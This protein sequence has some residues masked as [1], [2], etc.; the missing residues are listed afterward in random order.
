MKKTAIS[1][2]CL[3]ASHLLF[4]QTPNNVILLL[5][6]GQSNAVGR[7]APDPANEVS[8]IAGT[9]WYKQSTN[10]IES[11]IDGIGENVSHATDRSM[12]PMLG[13]RIKELTGHD[14][15]IVP[16]GVGNTFISYW[17][18]E[19]NSLYTRAKQMWQDALAYCA[20]HNITV[21]G[22][23][24]HWLQGEND[25]GPTET[26]GYY[27]MLNQLTNDLIS[28]VG[29]EKVFATRI[30]YDPN[31]TVAANSEKIMKA[32]KILNYNNPNFIMDSYAPPT[33]TYA[34]GK[35]SYDL[36]HHALSGLN[37][38][39]NDVAT[40]I[41][42]YRTAGG[43]IPLTE[44]VASLQGVTSGYINLTPVW[45]FD[46]SN[47]LNEANDNVIMKPVVRDWITNYATTYS[48]DGGIVIN[49]YTG[50][51]TSRPFSSATFT[52]EVRLRMTTPEA[53]SAVVGDGNGGINNKLVIYYNTNTS[54]LY[55]QF[56]TSTGASSWDLG[57][58][59]NMSS[60]HTLKF[61]Q[62][63]GTLKFY[64]DGVQKGTDVASNATFTISRLGMG[65]SSSTYDMS[66]VIDFFR[67]KNTVD[68]TTLPLKFKSFKATNI[69]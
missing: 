65:A 44:T 30:A 48:N 24:A 13:K 33:F 14:V 57:N 40:A 55:V 12:N 45:S 68:N 50:L 25:A 5:N 2:L 32:Q 56:G 43:K 38:E 63:N 51:A 23:Y 31:Y 21:S 66:G 52:M 10:T 28:D 26:D 47:N 7:A 39:A 27:V 19:D 36:S 11:L 61:T 16:A 8:P 49:Q 53:W 6:I 58:T 37:Q 1:L 67:I 60:Y 17:L 29:V 59:V 9:Y 18:K 3:F 35:M 41:Q 64:L 54:A 46:F 34:N 22:K 4:S 20:A 62:A 42:Y 69:K 15:I